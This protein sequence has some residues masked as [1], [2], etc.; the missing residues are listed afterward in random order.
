M[1]LLDRFKL[2]RRSGAAVEEI[3]NQFSLIPSYAPSFTTFGG[4]LYEMA[5]TR[6]AIESF[7]QHVSQLSPEFQGTAYAALGKRMKTRVNYSMSTSTFLKRVATILSV[8]TSVI[9]IPIL[10]SDQL[11]IKGYYPIAPQFTK[12]VSHEGQHWVCY[13]LPDGTKSALE[14]HRVGVLTNYQYKNDFYGDGNAP[15]FP[16]MALMDRHQ[17]G[18]IEAIEK[19]ANIQFMAKLGTVTRPE[20]QKKLRDDF[21]KEQLSVENKSSIMMYDPKLTELKQIDFKHY[22]PDSEQIKMIKNNVYDYFGTNE[23]IIQSKFTDDQWNA[24]YQ[25][26]IEPFARQLSQEMTNMTF[27]DNE[28]AYG[29]GIMF[30]TNNMQYAS[31]SSKLN[32]ASQMVDRGVLNRDDAREIFNKPPLPDGKGQ[33]YIIRGEYVE[34][35]RL[36]EDNASQTTRTTV[37]KLT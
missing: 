6:S 3:T 31:H 37:Q 14:R 11:T 1:G 28:I 32:V 24:Y 10:D 21:A 15:L 17:Q 33:E 20:D 16:S 18:V 7:A 5:E 30:T 8:N 2:N 26:K 36:G 4:G 25:S 35:E 34:S 9:I 19:T 29:N 27:T 22:V 12:V 23:A 13:E